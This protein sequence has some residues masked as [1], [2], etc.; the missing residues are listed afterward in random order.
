[1]KKL[2]NKIFPVALRL[3]IL[4]LPEI[5]FGMLCSLLPV[6][7]RVLFYTIRENGKLLDNS[8]VLYDALECEKIVFASK[9]PHSRC[10]K[11]KAIRL[12]KTSKVIVTDD[13]CKY[14]RVISLNDKQKLIQIW[15]ACGSFKCFGLDAPSLLSREQEIRTHKR[16]DL[17][18]VTGEACSEHYASAFGIDKSVIKALGMP[19]TDD[20]VNKSDEMRSKVYADFPELKNKKIYLYCPTFREINGQVTQFN[21]QID[22]A[23]LNRELSD[24]EMFIVCRHPLENKAFFNEKFD[25]AVDMTGVSTTLLSSVSDVIITDYSSIIFD[26]L[27]FNVPPLFYCPDYSSYERNFY[28]KFPEDMPGEMITDSKALLPAIR[29]TKEMPPV[30]KT[31]SF[32]KLQLSACDGKATERLTKYITDCLS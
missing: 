12:L 16:Y 5:I 17:V 22:F 25:K 7:N 21:P 1:M 15:H 19:R 28:L 20:I 23:L 6:K 18:S 4:S 3:K 14:M 26:A 13:Y 8:K 30:E 24:D 9:L 31:D 2:L 27:L 11:F 10:D 29:Q 32:K